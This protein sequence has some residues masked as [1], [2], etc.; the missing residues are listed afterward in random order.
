MYGYTVCA[1]RFKVYLLRRRGRRLPWRDV[2]NGKTYAGTLITHVEQHNGEQYKV[3]QLQPSDPMSTDKPPPL[4]EA[5]LVGFA[6]LAI[7]L[8]GFER[9]EGEAGGYGV[10]QEWH[11]ELP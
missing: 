4:Y 5:Q 11:V 2:Q 9:V 1:V 8:R 10:V 7:R 6:T 3:L